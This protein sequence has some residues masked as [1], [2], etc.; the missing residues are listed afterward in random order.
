MFDFGVGTW[1]KI[2]TTLA[3]VAAIGI[4]WG[5]YEYVV[6]QW[7]SYEA[8][9]VDEK[10]SHAEDRANW[11][12][13]VN[14]WE[15]QKNELV[16]EIAALKSEKQKVIKHEFEMFKEKSKKVS[17]N[18][19]ETDN[20]IKAVSKPADVIIVPSWF[21][22]VYNHAVEGSRIASGGSSTTSIPRESP[23]GASGPPQT[24]DAVTFAEVV[25]ANVDEY[26]SL[27]LQCSKL[28]DTVEALEKANEK[29]D[30]RGITGTTSTTGR[31]LPIGAVAN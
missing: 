10:K 3:I 12:I 14:K 27:A 11:T 23:K 15:G 19:K 21:R 26:N 6:H 29:F 16:N 13:E 17:E 28:I 9:Y 4:A 18:K 1:V 5:R 8:K 31:N 30:V 2:A 22:S 25:K 20:E 7:H 24:F